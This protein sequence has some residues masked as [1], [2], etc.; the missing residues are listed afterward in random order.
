MAYSLTEFEKLEKEYG[1]YSTWAVWSYLKDR[2]RDVTCIKENL[3]YLNSRY[4]LIALNISSEIGI[5]GNF[6]GRHCRKLKYALNDSPLRGSYM[7]DLFKGIVEPNSIQFYKYIKDN[8][9]L[10][11]SNVELF[12]KEMQA[13]NISP[14][15]VF[16]IFG[17]LTAKLYKQYFKGYFP[18]QKTIYHHHYSRRGTDKDW[19][20]G[21]WDKVGIGADFNL[22]KDKYK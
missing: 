1:K 7:T 5:W 3:D 13:I 19:V 6:R 18:N 9:E 20:E 2:E 14:D 8:I 4:V 12:K 22:I 16:L 11:N 17:N 15:T 21:F 10:I